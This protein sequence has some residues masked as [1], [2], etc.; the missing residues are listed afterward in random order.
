MNNLFKKTEKILY[1]YKDIDLKIQNIN[2][3]INRLINDVSVAGVSYEE[4]TGPTNAFSSSIENEVIRRDEHMSNELKQLNQIKKD[5]ITM[6][7]IVT[8]ALNTLNEEEYKLVEL[9]Y[10]QKSKK[11]WLEIGMKLGIDKDNCCKM[12]NKIINKLTNYIYP[13]TPSCDQFF[14]NF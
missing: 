12:K 2:L 6:Q 4:R 8:N 3:H 1:D 14:T 7:Q 11:T 13:S 9:R 10:F 5:T